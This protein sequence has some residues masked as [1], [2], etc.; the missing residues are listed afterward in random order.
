MVTKPAQPLQPTADEAI[1]RTV[2]ADEFVERVARRVVELLREDSDPTPTA[3][4]DARR[5]AEEFGVSRDFV[6][7]HADELGAVALGACGDGRRPR[8]RFDLATVAAALTDRR[9]SGRSQVDEMPAKRDVPQHRR[10]RASGTGVELLPIRG[11]PE[12]A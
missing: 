8:L 5:V 1:D 2:E 9:M 4:V 6:Y 10:A 11:R 3:W 7:A 12:A